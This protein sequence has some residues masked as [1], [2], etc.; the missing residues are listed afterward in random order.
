MFSCSS[1]CLGQW[2]KNKH[3]G[4]SR[5]QLKLPLCVKQKELFVLHKLHYH[6]LEHMTYKPRITVSM[7]VIFAIQLWL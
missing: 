4:K 6:F 1:L 5:F 2:G 7:R 3:P